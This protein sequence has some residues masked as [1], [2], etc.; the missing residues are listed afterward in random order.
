MPSFSLSCEVMDV[1]C[2]PE[3]AGGERGERER[4]SK[5]V[6]QVR[7]GLRSVRPP[8][9]FSDVLKGSKSRSAGVAR[10]PARSIPIV[11]VVAIIY[12]A[13]LLRLVMQSPELYRMYSQCRDD[14]GCPLWASQ[15]AGLQVGALGPLSI[16]DSN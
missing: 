16:L 14:A 9:R 1:L 5:V 8:G 6:L 12:F 15:F 7:S 2:W 3:P 10:L 11:A 4:A 13:I